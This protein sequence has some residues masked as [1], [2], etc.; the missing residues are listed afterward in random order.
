MINSPHR[1]T[2]THS[3]QIHGTPK[4]TNTAYVSL[5]VDLDANDSQRSTVITNSTQ[6]KV[7]PD[8]IVLTDTTGIEKGSDNESVYSEIVDLGATQ[9]TYSPF[10]SQTPNEEDIPNT[11]ELSPFRDIE[12]L[13]KTEKQ[14][15]SVLLSKVQIVVTDV[16]NKVTT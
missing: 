13:P 10:N 14:F 4:N 2:Y 6:D 9:T 7:D 8:D 1:P 11:N 3:V 16:N 15:P 5:G 12:I